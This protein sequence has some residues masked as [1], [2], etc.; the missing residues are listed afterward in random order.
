MDNMEFHSFG[1]QE[2]DDEDDAA[3]Q[4]MIEQSLLESNKQKDTP[5]NSTPRDSRRLVTQLVFFF[6]K[7]TTR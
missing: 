2:D 7:S 5:K 1:I 3:V 4:Y 6:A